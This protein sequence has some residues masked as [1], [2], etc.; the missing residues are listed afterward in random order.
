MFKLTF[1]QQVLTGFVISLLFVLLSAVTSYYSIELM[2][3]DA[4]WENHTYDVIDVA[5]DIELKVLNS[6]TSLRGY[7]ITQRSQYLETYTKNIHQILPKV[8]EMQRLTVDNLS[9]QQRLDSLE[10]YSA[11]KIKD[12]EDILMTNNTKGKEAAVQMIMTDKGKAYLF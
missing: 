9:Q 1:K 5:Q 11:Q 4:K 6:E 7:I 2:N 12:M 8:K 3:E 10:F